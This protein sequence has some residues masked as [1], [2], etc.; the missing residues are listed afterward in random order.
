MKKN[1]ENSEPPSVNKKIFRNIIKILILILFISYIFFTRIII[2]PY[3]RKLNED[4][5]EISITYYILGKNIII[6]NVE[7]PDVIYANGE[8]VT[9]S[10]TI[11][12]DNSLEYNFISENTTI[13]LIWYNKQLTSCE[14]M[15]FKIYY[16]TKIDLSKFDSSKVI[17]TI[18]MFYRCE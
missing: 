17:T 14:Y 2:V 10:I 7:F 4:Y 12:E 8:D 9:S 5:S 6:H 16:I 1:E 13:R 3:F 11:T 15:F 18:G